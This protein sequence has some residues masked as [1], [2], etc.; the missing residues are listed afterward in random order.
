M[1]T[2]QVTINYL[3]VPV[4]KTFIERLLA[5]EDLSGEFHYSILKHFFELNP[6]HLPREVLE[7]YV[8]VSSRE[9]YAAILPHTDKLF[10]R[11]LT[12]F[13]SAKRC[14]CLGEYLAS[15][16]L[17]AHLGE[18]LALLI[19]QI[20]PVKINTKDIDSKI[21]K[22]LWGREFEKMG[23]EQ[24]IDLLKVFGAINKKDTEHLD[25]LRTTRRKY[26]HFWSETTVNVKSDSLQCF[27]KIAQLVRD[28]LRIEYANGTVK[29]NPLLS[30][31][32]HTHTG[33]T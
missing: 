24:R 33:V 32:L 1:T 19:W 12:P 28:I 4:E 8:E 22:D 9:T 17:S 21:E 13:K 10:E 14:Y 11:F 20:T 18:M 7:R 5:G 15:I 16:E 26:F 31:Y 23:Q 25:F 29:L 6:E 3:G 30:K 2:I 27:L